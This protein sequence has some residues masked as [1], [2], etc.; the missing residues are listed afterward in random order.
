MFGTLA[1]EPIPQDSGRGV[2]PERVR[3]L[4]RRIAFQVDAEPG[5]KA[6]PG[7]VFLLVEP[8]VVVIQAEVI[9]AARELAGI[10][11]STAEGPDGAGGSSVHPT[12][13]GM[14]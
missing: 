13:I 8:D 12:G 3:V 2:G 10:A 11:A 9:N 1:R 7:E 4:V 14:G 6:I 5:E